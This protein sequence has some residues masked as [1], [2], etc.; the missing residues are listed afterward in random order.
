MQDFD[1]IRWLENQFIGK[2][3]AGRIYVLGSVVKVFEAKIID[4]G[5]SA[6]GKPGRN[7]HPVLSEMDSETAVVTKMKELNVALSK[8]DTWHRWALTKDHTILAPKKALDAANKAT[9]KELGCKLLFLKR[10]TELLNFLIHIQSEWLTLQETEKEKKELE[11]RIKL[12]KAS[13]ERER[14]LAPLQW[15]ASHQ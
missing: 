3:E 12:A 8:D 4:F 10:A 2:N 15:A 9:E 5:A 6:R 11:A 13:G 7:W 1:S 14:L